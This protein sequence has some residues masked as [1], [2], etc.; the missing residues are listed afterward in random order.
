[1]R[2]QKFTNKRKVKTSIGKSNKERNNEARVQRK[3]THESPARVLK[4]TTASK[5]RQKIQVNGNNQKHGLN[6]VIF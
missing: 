4:I 1:M 2:W 6:S 5:K 3:L